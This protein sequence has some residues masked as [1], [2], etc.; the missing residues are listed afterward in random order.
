VSRLDPQNVT[1]YNQRIAKTRQQL[2]AKERGEVKSDLFAFYFN[3]SQGDMSA[4]AGYDP[5]S[6][7]HSD[8]Y[9]VKRLKVP[10]LKTGHQ[11]KTSA[12]KFA[13]KFVVVPR[14]HRKH[15]HNNFLFG[16]KST[17]SLIDLLQPQVMPQDSVSNVGGGGGEGE[18]RNGHSGTR[19]TSLAEPQEPLR[20]VIDIETPRVDGGQQNGQQSGGASGEDDADHDPTLAPLNSPTTD[21]KEA[22]I[23][24]AL[25]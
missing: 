24:P 13:V 22:V 14:G 11:V 3:T 15:L 25:H 2:H 17:E 7:L 10:V 12:D 23:F 21:V 16:A 18:S 4:R 1:A 19:K 8:Y 9:S 5:N 20:K 6:E